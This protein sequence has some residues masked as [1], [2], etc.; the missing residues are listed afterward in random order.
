[1]VGSHQFPLQPP[2]LMKRL[3]PL[4][5]FLGALLASG[6][7]SHALSIPASEDTTVADKKITLA[8]SAAANLAVDP[9]HVALSFIP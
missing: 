7:L 6:G 9:T 8:A 5:C 2:L 3:F 1:M 4:L